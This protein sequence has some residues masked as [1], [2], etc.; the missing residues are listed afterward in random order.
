MHVGSPPIPGVNAIILGADGH[1]PTPGILKVLIDRFI[2][3]VSEQKNLFIEL[4]RNAISLPVFIKR[5]I[6]LIRVKSIFD[7]FN[8][9]DSFEHLRI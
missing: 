6:E 3:M 8:F 7:I 1:L 9:F 5:N 4:L 2:L